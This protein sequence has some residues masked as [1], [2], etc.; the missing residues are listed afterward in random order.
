[1]LHGEDQVSITEA[2]EILKK[3]N[4]DWKPKSAMTDFSEIEIL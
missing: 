3:W 4:P 2:L 1:M